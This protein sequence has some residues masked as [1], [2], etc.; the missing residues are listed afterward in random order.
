M[1]EADSARSRPE[2]TQLTVTGLV[3]AGDECGGGIEVV[4]AGLPGAQGVGGERDGFVGPEL[5]GCGGKVSGEGG[6]SG[7]EGGPEGGCVL[8]ELVVELLEGG[9]AEGH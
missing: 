1:A 7:A 2:R 6:V 8:R 4:R 3:E 9:F 5:R